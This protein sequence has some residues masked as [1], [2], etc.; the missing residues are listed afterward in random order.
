MGGS[1][2]FFIDMSKQENNYRLPDEC[3]GN[4][5]YSYNNSYD[6]ALCRHLT[7][8]DIIDFGGV[9]DLYSHVAVISVDAVTIS[10]PTIVDSVI[11]EEIIKSC[12]NCK[13]SFYDDDNNYEPTCDVDDKVLAYT[14]LSCGAWDAA[15]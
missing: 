6:D 4:C 5:T 10:E 14:N 11:K 1:L 3:C 12:E 15:D 8:I 9:C 2:P 7:S 13:H